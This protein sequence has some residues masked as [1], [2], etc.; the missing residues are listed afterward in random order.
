[1]AA[2]ISPLS[3]DPNRPDFAPYGLTCVHW[4]PSPMRRPDHHNEVE[5]N[6]LESGTV[7]YLL[8][9]TKTVVEAGKL[10]VFWAAIPH[11]IIDYGDE[12]AYY[13]AT[14]PLQCF[15]Q[16]RLP[17][18][19]V[20]PLMQ[21]RLVSEAST[22]RTASDAQ[23]FEHWEGDLLKKTPELERPVLLEMQARLIRLALNL[24]VRPKARPKRNR[25]TT[26]T[27]TGLN[28][29]EEIACFIAQNY[30]ERLTVQQIGKFAN[31]H[32]NYAMNLFQKTF[33]TTLINYLTQHR[34][35]HAQRLLATTDHSVT[36]IAFQS[37]FL[38][39]S[40]FNDA[41][42]RACGCSPREY[43][44]SHEWTDGAV[45]ASR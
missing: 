30:T 24:P 11:Q 10:S 3:F 13:V 15:L 22:D 42:R 37:G 20:Q 44:K 28:K 19:F 14:I 12:T 41:F 32:P 25:L 38:S 2:K 21:G 4:R 17:E 18:H 6:F 16:W 29:V 26:I 5:L 34:V 45:P 39:I 1:M 8:G 36:D 9:G 23:L 33:G 27:D 35:S 40:R 31:L 43:R 7:T